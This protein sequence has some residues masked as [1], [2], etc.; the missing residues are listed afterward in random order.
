MKYM[1]KS[2]MKKSHFIATCNSEIKAIN[3]WVSNL[4]CHAGRVTDDLLK[5]ILK[6]ICFLREKLRCQIYST[7]LFMNDAIFLQFLPGEFG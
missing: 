4:I 3:L 2:G 5:Q 6:A 1:V 7:T